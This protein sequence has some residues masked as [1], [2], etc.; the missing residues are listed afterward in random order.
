MFKSQCMIAR[1]SRKSFKTGVTSPESIA[2]KVT[3]RNTVAGYADL[4]L[5]F[6]EY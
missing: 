5:V 3:I 4:M 1:R 2:R 6:R